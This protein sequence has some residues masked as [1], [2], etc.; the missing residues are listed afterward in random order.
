MNWNDF[1]RI[2]SIHAK[3]YPHDS[4]YS[5]WLNDEAWRNYG[6]GILTEKDVN[7]IIEFLKEWKMGR[8]LGKIVKNHGTENFVS[9]NREIAG[10]TNSLFE[11]S[12]HYRFDDKVLNFS[13]IC[14]FTVKLFSEES[15]LLKSTCASKVMH[16]VNPSLFI[17]WDE[18]IRSHWGCKENANG[19]LNFLMRMKLE[20]QELLK[21][22]SETYQVPIDESNE[23]LLQELDPETAGNFPITRWIDIYNWTKFT[24]KEK[25]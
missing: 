9:M 23:K 3:K 21:D 14:P 7:I 10:K 12:T 2:T 4:D 17:M 24:R 1:S 16:M 25:L 5:D 8:V 19:Y 13:E 22:F 15:K 20:Y 11:Q 18:K 6:K